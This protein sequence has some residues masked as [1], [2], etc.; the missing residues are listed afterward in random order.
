MIANYSYDASRRLFLKKGAGVSAA[1][2]CL[3]RK[4][5]AQVC[6]GIIS[7]A[8]LGN[9]AQSLP[10]GGGGGCPAD[11]SAQVS[12]TTS[13]ATQSTWELGLFTAYGRIGQRGWSDTVD[14]NICKLGF[15][16]TK[17]SGDIS[18]TT[19]MAAVYNVSGANLGTQIGSDSNAIAG[20]NSWSATW[21]RFPFASAVT[22]LANTTVSLVLKASA[23][24][25]NSVVGWNASSNGLLNGNF[26]YWDTSGV[27]QN[28]AANEM[29]MEIYYS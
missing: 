25:G 10:A 5:I 23:Y 19:F 11:G 1:F 13:G 16:L 24:S 27:N 2:L 22:V 21:V 6:N 17:V 8:K 12:I 4:S 7:N 26:S 14:R 29:V 15:Y 18:G 3:P 9:A 28:D 20:N